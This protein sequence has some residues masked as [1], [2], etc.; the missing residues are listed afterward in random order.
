MVKNLHLTTANR[1]HHRRRP[2]VLV[3]ALYEKDSFS[4]CFIRRN[5][6]LRAQGLLSIVCP[7]RDGSDLSGVG[8]YNAGLEEVRKIMD[9]DPGVKEKIFI[10]E[11]HTGR[12]FPGDLLPA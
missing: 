11:I 10:Y 2:P 3:H 5:I 12:S 4:D 6:A 1:A 7:V 8:I 9:D